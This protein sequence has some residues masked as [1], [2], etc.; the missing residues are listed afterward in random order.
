MSWSIEIPKVDANVTR[1]KVVNWLVREGESVGIGTPLVEIETEKAVFEI[2]SKAAGIVRRIYIAEGG[3]GPVGACLGVI[4]DA[5][6][7]LDEP[8]SSSFID[9]LGDNTDSTET[10]DTKI[11]GEY[12]LGDYG[13][14]LLS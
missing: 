13:D 9:A 5:D 14:A 8:D 12:A 1:A 2:E 11:D 7:A 10:H 3:R 4:A 6:E